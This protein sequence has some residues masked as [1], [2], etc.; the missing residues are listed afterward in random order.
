MYRYIAE[1]QL[2]DCHPDTTDKIRNE[3]EILL[4]G[5]YFDEIVLR[6]ITGERIWGY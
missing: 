3:K 5:F 4:Q 1:F 2:H 6:F